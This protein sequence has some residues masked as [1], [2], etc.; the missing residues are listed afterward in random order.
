MIFLKL[1]NFKPTVNIL[2]YLILIKNVFLTIVEVDCGKNVYG[3]SKNPF[4]NA[5]DC[6][7]SECVQK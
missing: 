1:L 7:R 2:L 6:L 5:G 3:I 4:N